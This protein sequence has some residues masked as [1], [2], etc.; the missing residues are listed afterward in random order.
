[1]SQNKF[2]KVCSLLHQTALMLLVNK[3]R[4]IYMSIM[5]INTLLINVEKYRYL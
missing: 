3:C 1:M 5:Y 2:F 4:Y